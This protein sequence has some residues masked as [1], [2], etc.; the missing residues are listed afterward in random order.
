MSARVAVGNCSVPTVPYRSGG[1]MARL[2]ALAPASLFHR[3]LDR[4]DAGLAFGTIES[5]L[6][7]GSVRLLGGRGKGPVAVVHL[8]SWASLARMAL[9]GS[10]GWYRAWEA[11]EWS[12]PD[13]VPLFDSVHAQR[14]SSGQCRARAWPVALAEQGDPCAIHRN[15]RRGAK[16]NIHAH[17]DLGNDFYRLWL[18]SAM[19]YS[20][21]LFTGSRAVA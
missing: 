10:V 19:N 14:G 1:A 9:S 13:P 5:H 21:A 16:R 17:Y 3:I 11:G 6:P 7:D 8:H 2:I 12:S 4:I 20:S 15:D 18:D